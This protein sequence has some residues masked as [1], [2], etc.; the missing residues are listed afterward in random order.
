MTIHCTVV[1]VHNPAV[2]YLAWL[3]ILYLNI[4][5][6]EEVVLLLPLCFSLWL[7]LCP[8]MRFLAFLVLPCSLSFLSLLFS[9]VFLPFNLL[10][11][12]CV[13]LLL[14]FT[15]LLLE[16][17]ES[18][19]HCRLCGF[20]AGSL[21]V[22]LCLFGSL[23]RVFVVGECVSCVCRSCSCHHSCCRAGEYLGYHCV[24]F[25]HSFSVSV[26]LVLLLCCQGVILVDHSRIVF[27]WLI[28]RFYVGFYNSLCH[29]TVGINRT[30]HMYM[31]LECRLLCDI[32][33]DLVFFFLLPF[34]SV[35]C[36]FC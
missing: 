29:L 15:F 14:A 26:V 5:L 33:P 30:Y 16:F 22:G 19:L 25:L 3:H 10:L 27:G 20:L 12:S 18:L 21:V 11:L 2:R 1:Y 31:V 36:P 4:V 6:F 34:A 28:I 35:R 13:L 8:L 7:L 23:L 24:F 32:S 9:L 17:R